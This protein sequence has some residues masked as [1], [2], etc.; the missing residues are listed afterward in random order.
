MSTK[1]LNS[2]EVKWWI[3]KVLLELSGLWRSCGKRGDPECPTICDGPLPINLRI[4]LL[5][6][7]KPTSPIRAANG[8]AWSGLGRL[9]FDQVL[10]MRRIPSYDEERL[11]EDR[12]TLCALYGV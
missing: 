1:A 6:S 2:P 10:A 9:A 7:K 5:P 8:L 12:E 11:A 3:M 4:C